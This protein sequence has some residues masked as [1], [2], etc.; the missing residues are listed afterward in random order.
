MHS[1]GF[2]NVRGLNDLN[3]QRVVRSF[4]HNNGVGLF[5]L[6][7]TKLKPSILLNRNTSICDG[8]SVS[9]NCSWHKGSR[10]WVL[11]KSD[12][13]YIQFLSY[14]AQHIHM[15]VH[16]RVDDKNFQLT[17]I[18]AFNGLH[19]RIELW[20]TL[21]EI[22]ATCCTPWLWLR[23]FNT[24]LSP[25]ER[26]GGNTTDAEMEYFQDC[27]SIC[28]IEDIPATGAMFTWSNKQES[29]DRVCSRLDR[30]MGNQEWL[31][32]YATSLAHFHPEG[33]F[34]HCP[35]TIV[36]RNA[37]IGG[38]KTFKYFNMW[39]LAPSFKDFVAMAWATVYRGTKMFSVVKKLK[40][41]KPI[42]KNINRECFSDVENNTSVAS[43]ALE[44]IQKALVDNPGDADLIQ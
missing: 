7:E 39:G 34:D 42:L 20:N 12:L 19:E 21:K 18:Y 11:W 31:D 15:L 43:L 32:G 35:C 16:S 44:H 10:I 38:K 9:T 24:V 33:L 17:M 29:T 37:D 23:D 28:G 30:A 4:L 1:L 40:A 26:L 8:W 25:I 6:L 41:L 13:F 22:S 14:S 27:V 36:D 5:G 2:W 3:K